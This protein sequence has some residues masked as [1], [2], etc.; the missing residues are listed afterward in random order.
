MIGK[1]LKRDPKDLKEGDLVEIASRQYR[2]CGE[3]FLGCT[4]ASVF[5]RYH[6]FWRTSV[7]PLDG[8]TH[9]RFATWVAGESALVIDAGDDA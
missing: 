9:L 1:R 2:V 8:S 3:P 5:D 7:T 4:G 6:L